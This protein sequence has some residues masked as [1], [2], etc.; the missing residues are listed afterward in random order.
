VHNCSIL[1]EINYTNAEVITQMFEWFNRINLIWA[2]VILAVAHVALYF[3]LGNDRWFTLAVI[4]S[5]VDTGVIAVVQ[6]IGRNRNKE[7]NE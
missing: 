6:A 3:S 5:L 1:Q 4:A 7:T 2:F